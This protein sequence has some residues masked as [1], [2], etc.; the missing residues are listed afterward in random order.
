MTLAVAA[1][2][3]TNEQNKTFGENEGLQCTSSGIQRAKWRVLCLCQLRERRVVVKIFPS[4]IGT[5][6]P[7]ELPLL[8]EG[9]YCEPKLYIKFLEVSKQLYNLFYTLVINMSELFELN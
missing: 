3:K 9:N 2:I 4:A 6:W 7:L 5:P 8:V 1:R